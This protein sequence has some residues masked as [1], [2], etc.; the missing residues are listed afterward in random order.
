VQRRVERDGIHVGC[1]TFVSDDTAGTIAG[2]LRDHECSLV[3]MATRL[4]GTERE[5][6]GCVTLGVIAQSPCP[7]RVE[8]P[9]PVQQPILA[10]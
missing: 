6:F 4:R 1:R 7:V 8:Q 5:G 10:R 9:H 3:F 2:H